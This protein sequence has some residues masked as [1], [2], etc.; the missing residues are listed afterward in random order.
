MGRT[1][2]TRRSNEGYP[3][4]VTT[5]DTAS[6]TV[7]NIPNYGFTTLTANTTSATTYVLGAPEEGVRKTLVIS[8]PAGS[9]AVTV[10][11]S[12]GTDVK[13]DGATQT[14][15]VGTSAQTAVVDMVGINS[16]KWQILFSTSATPGS[17]T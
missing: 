2:R 3:G 1:S 10:R 12:V 9:A 5:A 4:Y 11:G 14:Q 6:S 8:C 16:T 7:V 15:V 17:T 13:F